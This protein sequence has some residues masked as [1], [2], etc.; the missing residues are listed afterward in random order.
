MKTIKPGKLKGGPK[1][2]AGID[3]KRNDFEVSFPK[4]SAFF[5]SD[6]KGYKKGKK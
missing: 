4:D 5:S 2:G 3:G 6:L 1:N